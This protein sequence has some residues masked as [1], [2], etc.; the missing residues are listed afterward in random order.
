MQATAFSDA[1]LSNAESFRSTNKMF[2][3]V[4]NPM[5]KGIRAMMMPTTKKDDIWDLTYCANPV[6]P[7][8]EHTNAFNDGLFSNNSSS[9]VIIPIELFPAVHG[10]PNQKRDHA[11]N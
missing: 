9:D 2:F 8:L 1:Q 5:S 7:S 10:G 3:N 11:S 6:G 4:L